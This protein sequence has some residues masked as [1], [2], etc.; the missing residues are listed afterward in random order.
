MTSVPQSVWSQ[1]KQSN[2]IV[3]DFAPAGIW[4]GI[5][6]LKVSGTLLV[7]CRPRWIPPDRREDDELSDPEE[8]APSL[9]PS[10]ASGCQSPRHQSLLVHAAVIDSWR[11]SC[12]PRTWSR[13]ANGEQ[14]VCA[15]R[16]LTPMRSKAAK[17]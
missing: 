8:T 14:E 9:H 4:M 17:S 6:A 15:R 16:S 7:N 10:T 13:R 3:A 11:A 2:F 5:F 12:T 1:S